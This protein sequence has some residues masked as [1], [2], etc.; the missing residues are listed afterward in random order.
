MKKLVGMFAAAAMLTSGMALANNE[1]Q[2]KDKPPAAQGGSGMQDPG[3]IGGSGLSDSQ[4]MG[5]NSVTGEV[6]KTERR[7]VF[8]KGSDGAVVELKVDN[9][10]QFADPKMKSAKDLK[11]GTAI[12][13][14]F[15]VKGT[16][17]IALHI[18]PDQSG[19]G[20]SGDVLSPDSGMNQG[21]SMPGDIGGSG[22][23]DQPGGVDQPSGLDQP[24]SLDPGSTTPPPGGDLNQ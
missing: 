8:L 9:K 19:M 6:I 5:G 21:D 17:N 16:D 2:K 4:A 10:T 12:R 18:Q 1:E 3:A 20:G 23:L 14:N 7:S 13:A 15:N 22:G 24:G 11:E